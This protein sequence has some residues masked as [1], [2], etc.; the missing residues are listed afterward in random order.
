MVYFVGNIIM[1]NILFDINSFYFIKY[2]VFKL[3][4]YFEFFIKFIICY[5]KVYKKVLYGNLKN[6]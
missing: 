2:L 1:V 4:N 5:I 6:I 3:Y